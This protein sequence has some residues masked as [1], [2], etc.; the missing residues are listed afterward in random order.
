MSPFA[1]LCHPALWLTF[2][3]ASAFR[4]SSVDEG[5]LSIYPSAPSDYG[6][7]S[8]RIEKTF[9]F[10]PGRAVMLCRMSVTAGVP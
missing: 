6:D 4:Q 10:N 7:C 3:V 8:K 2:S 1:V 5:D 9:K